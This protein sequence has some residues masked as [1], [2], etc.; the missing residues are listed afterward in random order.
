MRRDDPNIIAMSRQLAVFMGCRLAYNSAGYKPG[1]V[2]GLNSV[3]GLY[4]AYND[5]G[6]SGENT[7]VGILEK[8]VAATDFPG[9][10]AQSAGSSVVQ[11]MIVAGTVYYA[12]LDGI[13]AN[14]VTDLKGRKI[15]DIYGTD[16]LFFG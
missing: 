9:T 12:K 10:T 3:S 8:G 6:S 11:P 4:M 7:A 5:A 2:L 14:G 15:T 1:C 13:D 16:L